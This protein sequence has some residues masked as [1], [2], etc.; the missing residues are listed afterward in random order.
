VKEALFYEKQSNGAVGCRLCPHGCRIPEG[1]TGLCNVRR[2]INGALYAESCG[3]VTALNL[4]PIEKK[5]LRRFY[6]GS[7]ILSVGSYGCNMKCCFCQNSAIS[8]SIPETGYVAPEELADKAKNI[9]GNIGVAFTYN[10]PL[11][12]VEYILDAAPL[13]KSAGL[14]T[15]LVTNGMIEPEPLKTLLSYVDAMNI[16]VKCFSEDYYK[17]LGGAFKAVK[18]TVELSAPACHVEVTTLI[19]PGGNDGKEE[20]GDLSKW[21]S[22][23]SPEIPLH[24]SRFFPRHKMSEGFP[25]PANTL[26]ALK[27][28]AEKHLKYVYLGNI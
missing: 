12:G 22:G 19:V 21:L 17:K 5:P 4:D 25:T 2:N 20:I 16:D 6:P 23:I 7:F 15:V 1:G 10:E 11:V 3:R 18:R 24:L 14:K 8:Q 9:S 27:G 28:I 26:Y 13:L